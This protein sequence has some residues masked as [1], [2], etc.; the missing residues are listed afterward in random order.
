MFLCFCTSIH[1]GAYMHVFEHIHICVQP[2][3]IC[4]CVTCVYQFPIL[5]PFLAL[6]NRNIY[7]FP[8]N[9]SIVRRKHTSCIVFS[10]IPALLSLPT[11][12]SA[13]EKKT[14]YEE[15]TKSKCQQ[16]VLSSRKWPEVTVNKRVVQIL[17]YITALTHIM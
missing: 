12:I 8:W 14:S 5:N 11:P 2:D 17:R 6:Q 13:P 4:V 3:Q 9:L 15:T 1:V 10:V 16:K 7:C